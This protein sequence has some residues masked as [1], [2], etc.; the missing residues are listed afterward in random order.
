MHRF[1]A[2]LVLASFVAT[3]VFASTAVG[4]E[5]TRYTVTRDAAGM[6]AGNGTET[7]HVSVCDSGVIHIVAGPGDPKAASPHEPWIVQ[8]CTPAPFD[9]TENNKQATVSTPLVKVTIQFHAGTLSFHSPDG[10][11]L[12][13]EM[14]RRGPNGTDW[15]AAASRVYTPAVVNGENVYHT[16]TRFFIGPFEGFYGLG[17]HQSGAFNYRGNV[18]ELAQANTDVALPLVLSTNG[19]GILWNTAS[20]SWF[21]NR[22]PTEMTL[23]ALAA[24]AIDYYFLYGPEFDQI[25]HEYRDLTGHAPLFGKWAYGFVQSKDRYKSAKELLDI[26]QEYRDQHVPLDFIVQDWFW[27]KLQGDPIFNDEYLKPYPDVP[28]AIQ[29]LHDEHFHAMIS[30]WA[31]LDPKSET[32]QKMKAEGLTIPNITIYDATNPKARDEYWNLLMG[33]MFAHG[34][35][36]FWLDSSEP[37]CCDGNS[38]ATLDSAQLFFGNGA[39][40]TNV[41]P[42]MHTGGVYEHWRA[43]TDR[44]RVFLLTRS[45]F[46]GQQRNATTVWS[47]DVTGTFRTFQHQIPAGLNFELSGVPYWTTDIAGYGWPY[48]RSTLDPAYQELYTRWFEFGTFC[49][50]MRTHG[51]RSNNTNEIFSYGPQVPTLIEYDKLRYRMLPYIYSLAWRVT[52]DDYTIMRP[53]VMDWRTDEKV[54][55]I[56]DEYLFGPSILVLPVDEQGVVSRRGYLPPAPGW[57][58]FWTGRRWVGDQKILAQAPLDRIPLFVKAGSILPLGPEREYAM[59]SSDAPITLRIYPGADADFTLYNDEGDSYDYEK[60]E[61]ATVALHWDD[62]SH[63]LTIGARQGSYPGMPASRQFRVVLVREG[64]GAGPGME[65][66]VDKELTYDG[67]EASVS[68]R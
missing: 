63:T 37:E 29:K 18:V 24:D 50:I 4:A 28:G 54:R 22:F 65:E 2:R 67:S 66:Q 27:W 58:D 1:S 57:Y 5:L 35:D 61:H 19:Y 48:E 56:G 16:K 41:Y 11:T 14:D 6:T 43:T 13:A 47:G 59:E 8:A 12:L 10:K 32:Y 52:N 45:A 21:D 46:A 68:L 7:V 42:L 64:V 51:H 55:D 25:I 3:F 49:P 34:W 26:G 20:H 17:Q 15:P 23:S 38:D 60:G 36:G 9:F 30:V 39:R 62:A 53:L 40:Y 44:K 33:K 31:M